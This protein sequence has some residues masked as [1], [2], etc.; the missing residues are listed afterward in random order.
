MQ[1]S[2]QACGIHCSSFHDGSSLEE[3]MAALT[4]L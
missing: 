2:G 1:F 4:F 3:T